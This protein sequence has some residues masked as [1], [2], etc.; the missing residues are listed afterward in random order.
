M[1]ELHETAKENLSRVPEMLHGGEGADLFVF[2]NGAE[3]DT[4]LDLD[5]GQNTI[6]IEGGLKFS[7]LVIKQSGKDAPTKGSADDFM[8]VPR[9][10]DASQL[11]VKDFE[12]TA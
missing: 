4:I 5:D 12:F 1:P 2:D 3:T 10:V 6:V 7:D 9:D 8:V 11:G